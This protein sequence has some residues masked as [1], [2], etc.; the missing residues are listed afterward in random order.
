MWANLKVIEM[1]VVQRPLKR[2]SVT[3]DADACRN[4]SP[5][6]RAQR[7]QKGRAA[8]DQCLWHESW[9]SDGLGEEKDLVQ[10]NLGANFGILQDFNG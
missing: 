6:L 5:P 1:A 8:Y 10:V 3:G 4:I 7:I 9:Q 2:K